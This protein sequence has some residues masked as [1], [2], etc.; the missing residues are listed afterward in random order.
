MSELLQ[1]LRAMPSLM[2]L[3]LLVAVSGILSPNFLAPTNLLS[4]VRQSTPLALAAT[5]QTF[6]ILTGGLDLSVGATIALS[7]VLAV[8]VMQGDTGM[9]LPGVLIC[10]AAGAAVGLLNGLLVTVLRIA[11]FIATLATMTAVDGLAWV[12]TH[13]SPRG[14]AP[15]AIRFL[16]DGFFG[17][18]PVA[19]LIFLAGVAV[20][21]VL[22]RKTIFGRQVYATG[23]NATS[24]RLMGV[25]VDRVKVLVFVAS[26]LYAAMAGIMLAGYVGIGSLEIGKPY[27][28]D[29]VAAVLIGGTMFEG[30]RGGVGGT[31]AGVLVLSVLTGILIR[32]QV[33]LAAR[34]IL[35]SLVL[36]AAA[37]A[38]ARRH[39]GGRSA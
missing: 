1:R 39:A 34:S 11:P 19:S 29:S 37:V 5:G 14:Q 16:S 12:Y 36:I 9:T 13:G 17:P 28:L 31:A 27:I 20:A 6:V 7:Q 21:A 8:G 4:L 15:G 35:L 2:T 3:I 32:L 25:P 30:G 33:P 10:L 23:G 26:G 24:A 38:Y 18:I 22:L